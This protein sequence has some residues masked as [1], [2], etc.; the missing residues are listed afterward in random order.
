MYRSDIQVP[1]L[2]NEETNIWRYIDLRKYLSMLESGA[3]FFANSLAFKDEYEG[4]GTKK[5]RL[6]LGVPPKQVDV[7]K[8]RFFLT[9]WYMSTDE[10]NLMWEKY[11]EIDGSIA[12]M[13]NIKNIKNCLNEDLSNDFFIGPVHYCDFEN[14]ELDIDSPLTRHFLKRHVFLYESE[15][16]AAYIAFKPDEVLDGRNCINPIDARKFIHQS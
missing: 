4:L 9:C 12:I 8:Q 10:S 2:P 14:D 1:N 11:G 13:S 6:S 5:N 16:R 7:W 15:L 3:L